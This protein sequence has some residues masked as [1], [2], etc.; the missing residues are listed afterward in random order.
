MAIVTNNW[1]CWLKHCSRWC[2]CMRMTFRQRLAWLLLLL[3]LLGTSLFLNYIFQINKH[4]SVYA[5]EHNDAHGLGSNSLL[6]PGSNS[7]EILKKTSETATVDRSLWTR[8]EDVLQHIYDVPLSVLVFIFFAIYF[9]VF[10]FLWTFTRP[11]VPPFYSC[12]WPVYIYCT[13]KSKCSLRHG[14]HNDLVLIWLATLMIL[15]RGSEAQL[16]LLLC[17]NYCQNAYFKKN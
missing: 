15:I 2:C 10:C 4:Y 6:R 1:F 5:L 16:M 7:K 12:L 9:Q 13:V 14:F 8:F 17:L 11:K 3:Y